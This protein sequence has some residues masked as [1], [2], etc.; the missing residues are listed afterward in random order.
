MTTDSSKTTEKMVGKA[1]EVH[2]ELG[3]GLLESTYQACLASEV[4]ERGLSFFPT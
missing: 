4:V 1:F 2:S 3:S